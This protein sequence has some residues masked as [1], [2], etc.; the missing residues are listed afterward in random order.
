MSYRSGSLEHQFYYKGVLSC[1]NSELVAK[2]MAVEKA[3]TLPQLSSSKLYHLLLISFLC[4]LLFTKFNAPDVNI[5]IKGPELTVAADLRN[6]DLG[7]SL[8]W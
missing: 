4:S 7:I 3:M 1:A 6:A 8:S 2:A 5:D